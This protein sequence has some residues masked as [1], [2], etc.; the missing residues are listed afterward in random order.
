MTGWT[1]DGIAVITA[2]TADPAAGSNPAAVGPAANRRW[3][4]LGGAA[5]LVTDATVISRYPLVVELGDGT[6]TSGRFLENAAHTA[7]LTVIHSIGAHGI[8]SVQ[9]YIPIPRPGIELPGGGTVQV[10]ASNLQAG[11]NWGPLYYKYK[12]KVES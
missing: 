3:L 6:N 2:A 1:W 10:Q 8:V 7:S 11:D 4:F 12:E 5:S 9:G